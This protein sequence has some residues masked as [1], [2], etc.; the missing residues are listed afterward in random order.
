MSEAK[1]KKTEKRTST[2]SKP[3]RR[4]LNDDKVG[5]YGTPVERGNSIAMIENENGDRVP[6]QRGMYR[7][8]VRDSDRARFRIEFPEAVKLQMGDLFTDNADEGVREAKRYVGELLGIGCAPKA[9]PV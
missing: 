6:M 8:I 3:L 2:V 7:G 5:D 4:F 9:V 1:K